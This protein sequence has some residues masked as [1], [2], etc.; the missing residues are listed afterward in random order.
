M[1]TEPLF[2]FALAHILLS[3]PVTGPAVLGASL[4]CY[5]QMPRGQLLAGIIPMK[6]SDPAHAIAQ[7]L[8]V[9]RQSA[10]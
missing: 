8:D 3:E 6:S 10:T 4:I 1:G 5:R 2:G 9:Q 7:I